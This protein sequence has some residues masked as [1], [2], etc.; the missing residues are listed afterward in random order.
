[1]T[2]HYAYNALDRTL[3]DIRQ[4]PDLVFGGIPTVFGGDFA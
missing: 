4:A 2:H 1:M 3:R